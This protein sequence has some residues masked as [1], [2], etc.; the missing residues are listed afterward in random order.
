MNYRFVFATGMILAFTLFQA[1]CA[2]ISTGAHLDESANFSQYQ[3]FSWI[4]EEPLI[5]GAESTGIP[6]SPLTQQKIKDA[7]RGGFE[8]RG[9]E[10]VEDEEQADFVV[11]YTIGTRQEISIHSYPDPYHG[12]W[13][14]HV[15]GS[16]YYV[17]E[18]SAHTYTKGTLGVDVFDRDTKKPVWHGWVEKTVTS[19]DRKDPT[20]AI[21][22][23]VAKMLEAF[24]G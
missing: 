16:R 18:V 12:D 17:S 3:K 6:I 23:G 24:P 21:E 20:P 4:D 11:A 9:F 5:V 15:R 10:F 14:W 8:E 19:S 13:G 7:I 2:T 1:G 22:E